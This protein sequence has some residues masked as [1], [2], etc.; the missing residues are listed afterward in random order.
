MPHLH[1]ARSAVE[2]FLP[3]CA[4]GPSG[5][6]LILGATRPNA[7]PTFAR[8]VLGSSRGRPARLITLACGRISGITRFVDV[9]QP[10]ALSP[11]A[12][13][14]GWTAGPVQSPMSPRN[15][16][17]WASSARVSASTKR[18]RRIACSCP[19]IASTAPRATQAA[20]SIG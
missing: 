1:V 5:R 4:G 18:T 7:Q 3:A 2:T 14:T 6:R 20:A 13:R 11:A 17:R 19:A 9:Q 10:V 16:L 12:Q 15:A 8:F